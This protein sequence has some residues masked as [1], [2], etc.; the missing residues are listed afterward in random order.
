MVGKNQSQDFKLDIFGREQKRSPRP[1]SGLLIAHFE[2][3]TL[4]EHMD[5]PTVGIRVLCIV[6]PIRTNVP[7]YSGPYCMPKRG[8]LI[9]V[10]QES[11][12]PKPWA[13]SL[14]SDSSN[15]RVLKLLLSS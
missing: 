4:R 11:G 6:R 9:A 13:F 8:D 14:K 7:V 15:S 3:S 1:F 12:P 2:I 5:V 10:K